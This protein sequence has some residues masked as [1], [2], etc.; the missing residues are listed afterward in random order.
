[1]LQLSVPV[2]G[3]GAGGGVSC[4]LAGGQQAHH[5]RAQ[6]P[7]RKAP[8]TRGLWGGWIAQ[9]PCR[10]RVA[11]PSAQPQLCRG[12]GAWCHQPRPACT[13]MTPSAW[14]GGRDVT[15]IRSSCVPPIVL[16]WLKGSRWLSN[17]PD[18]RLGTPH[19]HTRQVPAPGCPRCVRRATTVIK[20]GPAVA[21]FYPWLLIRSCRPSSS[22]C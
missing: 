6:P 7:H 21:D 22:I 10:I 13:T 19:A 20:P 15:G 5:L 8:L 14:E 3:A 18:A 1:M 2:V 17:S 12:F 16:V 9:L 4:S 11:L